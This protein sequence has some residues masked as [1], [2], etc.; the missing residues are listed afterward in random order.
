MTELVYGKARCK[1]T[2]QGDAIVLSHLEG[3]GDASDLLQLIR[4]VQ[5][6][7]KDSKIYLSVDSDNPRK[8][9]L[10]NVYKKLGSKE[11]A[12]ILEVL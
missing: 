3:E 5:E 8:E 4:S 6:G 9:Q 1:A 10:L 11:I 7:A 12:T 2:A